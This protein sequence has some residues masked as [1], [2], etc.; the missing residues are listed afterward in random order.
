MCCTV[1]LVLPEG[2]KDLVPFLMDDDLLGQDGLGT[3]FFLDQVVFAH[4]HSVG[5][6]GAGGREQ[7]VEPHAKTIKC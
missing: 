3:S 2:H 5:E 7:T 1:V 4:K 6:L